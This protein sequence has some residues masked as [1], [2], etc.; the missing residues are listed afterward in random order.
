MYLVQ[1][2]LMTGGIKR[3]PHVLLLLLL[4]SENQTNPYP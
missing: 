3:I 4:T 1:P 2:V